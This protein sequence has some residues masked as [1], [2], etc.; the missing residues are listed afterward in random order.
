LTVQAFVANR[1]SARVSAE[2]ERA[3]TVVVGQH[4]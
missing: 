3:A 2:E 4:M 1:L